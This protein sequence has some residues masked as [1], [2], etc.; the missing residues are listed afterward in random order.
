MSALKK[1][2][3]L[4]ITNTKSDRNE[5]IKKHCTGAVYDMLP[6]AFPNKLSSDSNDCIMIAMQNKHPSL[7]MYNSDMNT[8]SMSFTD[9]EELCDP[10]KECEMLNFL[11]ELGLLPISQQCL[12]CGN[13]MRHS[14][15]SKT[16]YWICTRR[17]NGKKCNSAKFSVR[18]GTFFDNSKL[19]IQSILRI[20]WN[21]VHHLS[22]EQCKQFVGI[23]TKTNHTVGE[24]YCD[25]RNICNH[26]IR[27]PR[28]LPKLGG[29]GVIVEM[30]ESYFPGQPKFNRGRRLG[31]T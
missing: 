20:V 25:C 13:N 9:F 17:V 22:E 29:F 18:R 12:L 3:L 11:T 14:K 1:Q 26:C 10:N 19:S 24:Y 8:E 6:I 7:A 27:D 15:Q 30:D 23:S 2:P 5:R 31:T 16:W 4:D 21:F 28:N